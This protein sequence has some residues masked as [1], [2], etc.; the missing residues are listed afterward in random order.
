VSWWVVAEESPLRYS[1]QQRYG[2]AEDEQWLM[3]DMHAAC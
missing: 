1:K 3:L 2:L